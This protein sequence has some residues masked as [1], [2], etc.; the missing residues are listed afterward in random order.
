MRLTTPQGQ[1]LGEVGPEG[2]IAVFKGI[3][4]AVPPVGVRRWKHAEPA[5]AWYGLRSAKAAGPACMQMTM[6]ETLTF[7][8]GKTQPV[9]YA[10]PGDMPELIA[11]ELLVRTSSL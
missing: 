5:P 9:L 8:P 3:P 10:E 2:G 11:T 1:L 6:P 7:G 4:F